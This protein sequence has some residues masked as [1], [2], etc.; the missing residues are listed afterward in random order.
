M[1]TNRRPWR[2]LRWRHWHGS[3]A[4]ANPCFW[5]VARKLAT[6][7]SCTAKQWWSTS[8]LRGWSQAS[9]IWKRSPWR[10]TMRKK[11]HAFLCAVKT[12]ERKNKVLIFF[13]HLKRPHLLLWN[14][15]IGWKL[16]SKACGSI[17]KQWFEIARHL[18]ALPSRAIVRGW[19][20]FQDGRH[21]L[22]MK[23]LVAMLF[24]V[25]VAVWIMNL[26]C[27]VTFLECKFNL[28][29]S[30][31]KRLN[32]SYSNDSKTIVQINTIDYGKIVIF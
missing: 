10:V 16:L 1:Y 26:D 27:F 8:L 5:N 31:K 24:P 21:L 18:S 23:K 7:R 9:K 25:N 3:P 19:T 32:L 29:L 20:S 2:S 6:L 4:T 15:G 30:K 13:V 28:S 11:V 12:K 17:T 14:A 22:K